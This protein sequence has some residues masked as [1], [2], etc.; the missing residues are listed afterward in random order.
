MHRKNSNIPFGKHGE[1]LAAAYLQKNGYRIL[2]RNH[3]NKLGEMDIIAEEQGT[4]CFVEVKT[5]AGAKSGLPFESIP[6]WKQQKLAKTALW[7]LTANGLLEKSARFDVVSV[8]ENPASG[9]TEIQVLKDAF[10]MPF[11]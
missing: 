2:E 5:R 8:L 1:D 4:I 7:Y 9:L 6:F 11:R 10:E 3:R